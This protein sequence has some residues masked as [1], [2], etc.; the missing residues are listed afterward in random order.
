MGIFELFAYIVFAVLAGAA[1]VWV[2]GYWSPD[3]PKTIDKAIWFVV[4]VVVA[5]VLWTAFGLS[6]HDPQVPRLR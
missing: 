4:L 6:G 3:H 5:V 1:A 2:I